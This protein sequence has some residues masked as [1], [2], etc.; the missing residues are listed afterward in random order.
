MQKIPFI[1]ITAKDNYDF[2]F[3]LGKLLSKKIKLRI[4]KNKKIYYKKNTIQK[5]KNFLPNI[6][7]R[8]SDLL[9]EAKAISSGAEVPFEDILVLNCEEEILD[10]FVPRCTSIAIYSNNKTMILGHNEDWLST[11]K[12]D[13]L[14]MING[15]VGLNKFLALSFIGQLPG[16]SCGLNAYGLAYT[17]NSL[18]LNRFCYGIPRNFLLRALLEAKTL[19]E[20]ESIVTIPNRSI[21]ANTMLVWKNSTME[22]IETLW[23]RYEIFY[24]NKC[25]IH[26]NHPLRKKDQHKNN[27]KKE[28]IIR[29]KRVLELISNKRKISTNVIKTILKDHKA[30]ICSHMDKKHSKYGVTIASAIINPNKK[31]MEVCHTNPCKNK[32][33]KYKLK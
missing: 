24:G 11:Y 23:H 18:N 28:S 9:T 12:K 4:E 16:T 3:R 32:Y 29:Y 14:I 19:K 31:Y 33:Y 5:A 21:N 15:K 25:L 2:G 1:K 20:A 30:K 6:K 10:F 22:D 8:F 13:G 17:V 27:T 26:T 7:K